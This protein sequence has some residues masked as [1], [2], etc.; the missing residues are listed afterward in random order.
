MKNGLVKKLL[1]AGAIALGS[2]G[3]VKGHDIQLRG[4]S[5]IESAP[6]YGGL[7]GTKCAAYAVSV[8]RDHFGKSFK[9]G[10]A[11]NLRYN[12]SHKVVSEVKGR[13]HFKELVADGTVKP[14][15]IVGIYYP[16]SSYLNHKDQ[17]GAKVEYT[18]VAVFAGV[19]PQGEPVF[20]HQ[21]K[22]RTEKITLNK[23][24]TSL[25]SDIHEVIDTRRH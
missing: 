13:N 3:C 9:F 10:D 20:Y 5:K 17:T 11:W 14:G 15:M 7:K 23:L 12:N 22:D 24:T 6:L 1:L 19:N 8:A 25:G 2:S 18:H 21:F 4:G 16:F